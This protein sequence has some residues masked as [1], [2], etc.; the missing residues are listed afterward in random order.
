MLLM[1]S[2]ECMLSILCRQLFINT[3][4]FLMMVVVVLEFSAPYSRLTNSCFEFHM[5]FNCRNAVLGFPIL[6]FTSAFDPL[7]SSMMLPKYVK[8]STIFACK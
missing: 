1:V 8:D 6:D 2:G 4:T 3:C 5:F 7:C